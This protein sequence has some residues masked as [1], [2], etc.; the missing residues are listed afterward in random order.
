VFGRNFGSQLLRAWFRG[1]IDLATPTMPMPSRG[2][3]QMVE[4]GS[5]V[6]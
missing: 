4:L 1:L 2:E 5:G 6:V 3:I